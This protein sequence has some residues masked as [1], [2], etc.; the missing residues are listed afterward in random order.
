MVILKGNEVDFIATDG[1]RL[2]QKKLRVKQ[3]FKK[4]E[5]VIIPRNILSE[6]ARL[7]KGED[8]K[9]EIKRADKQVIFAF[10][11]II[12]SSRV[13]EGE[14]PDFERIIPKTS[15]IKIEVDREEMLRATKLISVFARDSGNVA[16]IKV[17]KGSLTFSAESQSSGSGEEKI[18]AKID[19]GASDLSI[20]FNYRFLEDFLNSIE[21]DSVEIELTD[22]NAP[23]VFKDP[24]D[25]DYLHLIM[26]VRIQE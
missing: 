26:P 6:L 19:G 13:I 24:K 9:M 1:F 14:F 2:S 23:G 21:A 3:N 18:D 15:T 7:T 8:V 25:T 12:L 20:A 11:K 4:E 16:K 5:K 22:A 17:N 10:E